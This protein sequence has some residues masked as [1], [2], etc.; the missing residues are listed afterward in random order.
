MSRT[1]KTSPKRRKWR[2]LGLLTA[3]VVLLGLG[4]LGLGGIWIVSGELVRPANRVVGAPPADLNLHGTSLPSRSGSD[5]AVWYSENASATATIVLAHPLGGNRRV[6]LDRARLMIAEGYDVVLVDL[7]AH[8]ES[9]GDQITAGHLERMDVL[10]TLGFV[11]DRYGD[12][13]VGVIGCSLGGAATALARPEDVDAMVLEAVYPTIE[14]AVANRVSMRVGPLSALLT[15]ILLWQI[16]VRLGV[17]LEDMRP[18]DAIGRCGCPVLVL[19]GEQDQ[20]TTLDESK[21]LARAAGAEATLVVFE[22]AGHVDLLS[23]DSELYQKSVLPFL[24][25]SFSRE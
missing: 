17:E 5:L 10:A 22:G 21:R 12:R 20:R 19:A 25:E 7:Q 6:M 15:P 3:A 14:E 13:P 23:H 9:P 18:I 16:P 24:R 1:K 4:L 11:K 8:G 2:R